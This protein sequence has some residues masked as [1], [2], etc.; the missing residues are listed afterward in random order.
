MKNRPS[1]SAVSSSPPP[2]KS[3]VLFRADKEDWQANACLNYVHWPDH[4]Y[5]SGYRKAA[6]SL[7]EQVCSSYRDQDSLIYPIVYL[8]RH[9]TELILKDIILIANELL[10]KELSEQEIKALGRHGLSKLWTQLRPLLNQVCECA[11]N[12]AFPEEDLEGIDSYIQ[13]IQEYDP[14]GQRFRYATMK[15]RKPSLKEDLQHI[16]I[17]VFANAMEMLIEYIESIEGWFSHLC[18]EKQD[19]EQYNS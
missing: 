1:E 5:S 18:S 9:C 16:N 3:D 11:G 13:Q 8:Y 2:R 15:N 7:A 10:D 4:L 12:P 19:M 14:D 17:R 6:R